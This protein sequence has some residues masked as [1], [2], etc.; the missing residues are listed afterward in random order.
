MEKK[1]KTPNSI[2]NTTVN[3]LK[4]KSFSTVLQDKKS[5]IGRTRARD[6]GFIRRFASGNGRDDGSI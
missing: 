3:E 4:I 6:N 1:S 5:R 2:A